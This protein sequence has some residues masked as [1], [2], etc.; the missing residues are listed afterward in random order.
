[1][2]AGRDCRSLLTP[3]EDHVLLAFSLTA[4]AGLSTGIGSIIALLAKPTNRGFL[5]GSLGFSAGVMIY[6]SF[7]EMLP[8]ANDMLQAEHGAL[9]GWLAAAGFFG[10]VVLTALI[11]FVVPNV[12]NPHE[13][14]LVEEIGKPQDTHRLQRVGVLTAVAISVHNFPEGFATMFAAQSDI[15]LGVSVAI[16]VALHNIP[17]G[18]SVSAPIYYATGSRKKAFWFSFLSGVS[19][20]VGALLGYL[21]L[22]PFIN[23]TLVAIV[24]AAVAGVMVFISLDQLVPNAKKFGKEHHSVY[25][26]IGGMA[27]MAVSLLLLH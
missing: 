17:E 19:E 8:E 3:M 26:L 16:A 14:S 24:L 20:P 10:G 4:L 13:A 11:D 9:G 15:L 18:I 7:S 23:D 22:R 5:A 1:M 27:V 21:V 25:G 12:E 6:V 2:I